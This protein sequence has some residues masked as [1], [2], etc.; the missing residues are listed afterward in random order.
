MYMS[1]AH[2]LLRKV[3]YVYDVDIAMHEDLYRKQPTYLKSRMKN[4][5]AMVRQKFEKAYSS[6]NGTIG[7]PGIRTKGF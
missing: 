5:L 3:C 6:S 1:Y 4:L 2:V 7:V